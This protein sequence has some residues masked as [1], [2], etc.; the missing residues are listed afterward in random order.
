VKL[1]A[2]RN[3]CDRPAV[4]VERYAARLARYFPY[5]PEAPRVAARLIDSILD[6]RST[7]YVDHIGSTAVP[8]CG[9]KGIID[10]LVAYPAGAFFVARDALDQLGF[11]PQS[12]PEPF[13]ESRPM[14]VG[15]TTYRGKAYRVHAHVIR[16]GD[17]EAQNLIKFRD[18]LR[19]DAELVR[20][21]QVEKLSILSSGIT[22]STEYSKAK[23]DFIRAVL[24]ES[25]GS[26]R[27]ESMTCAP[28]SPLFTAR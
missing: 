4:K 21:Y 27:A 24:G 25:A 14:R 28:A 13:P 23:S 9:G 18:R 7:L 15:A 12:G 17:R 22:V 19:A 11:Q 20:A 6:C 1:L 5:D 16:S 8:G 26:S 3:L 2:A 10:L